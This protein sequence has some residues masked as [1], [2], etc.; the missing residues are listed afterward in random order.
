M[1]S[2]VAILVTVLS[3]ALAGSA[4]G[5]AANK[6]SAPLPPSAASTSVGES[7]PT[8]S[9]PVPS[10]PPAAPSR[11]PTTTAEPITPT[12]TARPTP[13]TTPAK[14]TPTSARATTRPS[15]FG[16][17][18]LIVANDYLDAG[19]S[20]VRIS[21]AFE[22]QGQATISSCQSR[23]IEGEE[24]LSKVFSGVA[25]AEGNGT[26]NQYV[27]LIRTET[28]ARRMVDRVT[29]WR[30]SCPSSK[31]PAHPATSVLSEVH[32]VRLDGESEG[33]WWTMRIS[34][35]GYTHTEVVA[36][37]RVGTRVSV[38]DV[39]LPSGKTV[40][41]AAALVRRSAARLV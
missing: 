41:S 32:Q 27:M 24:G 10:T 14:A 23:G 18:N 17:G 36:L 28:D 35:D 37:V 31:D 15:T 1:K 26:G 8:P 2:R 19:L 39:F 34:T 4:A 21:S 9:A 33:Q 29:D 13:T 12:S 3:T 22:G 16:V 20:P 25:N 11:I 6:A 7:T 30:W 5:F 38:V 40:P